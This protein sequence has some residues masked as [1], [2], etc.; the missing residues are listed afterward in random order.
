MLSSVQQIFGFLL[1]LFSCIMLPSAAIAWYFDEGEFAAFACSFLAIFVVGALLW[2]PVRKVSVSLRRRD[3]ALVVALFW[4]VI[5]VAGAMP[6]L[7]SGYLELSVTDAVFE[8]VS[9]FTTTGATVLTGLDAMPRSMLLYRHLTQWV[10]GMGIIVIAVAVLPLLGIGGAAL[11][12]AEAPGP[13]KGSKL[14]PRIA[15]TAKILW[16]I[17]LSMTIACVI[18]YF[19]AGMSWFD[20]ICHSFS[21][22]SVGAFSTHDESIGYF[23]STSIEL[24]AIVF[25]MAGAANFALHF[26]AV[27]GVTLR[28]YWHDPEF[29]PYVLTLFWLS[30]FVAVSLI[31]YEQY[32][33][34]GEAVMKGIF[35]AVSFMTTTGYVT[36]DVATWPP[37][38]A[39]I[40]ILSSFMGACGNSTGGGMKVVRWV[41]LFKQGIREVRR[42]VHPHAQFVTK[43]GQRAVPDRVVAGIWGFFSLYVFVFAL[44]MIIVMAL[45]LDHVTA[46]SAVAASLNNLGP[47]LGDVVTH[48]GAINDTAK[49]VL[50]FAM[51]L[52]RL[53]IFTLLVLL[54]PAFWQQ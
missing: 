41:L 5:G 19:L 10:G 38:L 46:F 43:L 8:S 32:P 11:Y 27:R 31:A 28:H 7:L 24:V 13:T 54:T 50:V 3:A 26:H 14:T 30:A 15:E 37:L 18:A 17:Y 2:W 21:T 48:Y 39:V 29:K 22:V 9:G 42:L 23:A 53:E 52:G 47:G 6:L 16:A 51:L 20:A 44:L 4:I 49:W 40:L 12:L 36:T 25:M 33:E 35:Q 34:I 1:M 45:G